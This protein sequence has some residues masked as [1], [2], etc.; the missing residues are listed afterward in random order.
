LPSPSG[1]D[2][3]ARLLLVNLGADR[4]LWPMAE[5]LTAPTSGASW[6][7]AWSSESIVYGGRGTGSLDGP[8]AVLPGH[9]ALLLA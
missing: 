1:V 2:V 6:T 8:D 7:L 4:P 5:P 9:S 3:Q